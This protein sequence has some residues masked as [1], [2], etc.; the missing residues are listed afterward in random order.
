MASENFQR[1]KVV[2]AIP[3]VLQ[4]YGRGLQLHAGPVMGQFGGV[5]KDGDS[6]DGG[7]CTDITVVGALHELFSSFVVI[8]LCE[9]FC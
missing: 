7:A 5:S 2:K 3:Q 4:Q 8:W 1:C 9:S 6:L